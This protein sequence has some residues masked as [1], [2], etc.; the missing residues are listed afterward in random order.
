M[1]G[2]LFP[3]GEAG[4]EG[5]VNLDDEGRISIPG[6]MQTEPG[7]KTGEVTPWSPHFSVL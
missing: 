6:L 3:R 1:S 2:G 4:H 7:L 5:A